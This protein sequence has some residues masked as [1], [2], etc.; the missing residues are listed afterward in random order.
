[1]RLCQYAMSDPAGCTKGMRCSYA[2]NVYELQPIKLPAGVTPVKSEFVPYRFSAVG[3]VPNKLC[4]H[5]IFD[6]ASCAD[7]DTCPYAH[8]VRELQPHAAE[9]CGVSRFLHEGY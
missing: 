9:T 6:P 4:Q 3:W 7:G 5:W 1:M 8:G 2:H